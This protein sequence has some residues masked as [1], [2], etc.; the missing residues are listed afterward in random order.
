M[1]L[2]D[3]HNEDYK[4]NANA[5]MAKTEAANQHSPSNHWTHSHFSPKEIIHLR[6][7][8]WWTLWYLVLTVALNTEDASLRMCLRPM[9]THTLDFCRSIW[10]TVLLRHRICLMCVC[11][12]PFWATSVSTCS[13]FIHLP[14]VRPTGKSCLTALKVSSL[15]LLV[16]CSRQLNG[17]HSLS[18]RANPI[19]NK[20]ISHAFD[21]DPIAYHFHNFISIFCQCVCAWA[22]TLNAQNPN[23]AR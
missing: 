5:W 3:D 11:A 15:G 14:Y 13:Q 6:P 8:T 2:F 1:P 20:P 4:R 9:R 12:V 22:A 21:I 16:G 23:L 19:K 17:L 7:N 18:I 10:Q